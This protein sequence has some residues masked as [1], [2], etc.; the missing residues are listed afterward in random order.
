MEIQDVYITWINT[1]N[2]PHT[3]KRYKGNLRRF[4]DACM[5]H[6]LENV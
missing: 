1:L 6:F 2:S 4:C 5:G 3:I